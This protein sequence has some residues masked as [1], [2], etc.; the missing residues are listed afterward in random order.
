MAKLDVHT[1]T[2]IEE[3]KQ[4]EKQQEFKHVGSGR[5]KPNQTLYAINTDTMEIYEVEI[6]KKTVFDVSK[7]KEVCSLKAVV[8]PKHPHLYALNKKNA[9]RKFN[10]RFN[11]NK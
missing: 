4:F 2:R 3:R 5:R 11:L 7:K 1:N 10:T 6:A 8:N 9:K